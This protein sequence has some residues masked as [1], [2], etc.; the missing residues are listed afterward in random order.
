[1]KKKI[2]KEATKTDCNNKESRLF[3]ADHELG[4]SV[5]TTANLHHLLLRSRED[6]YDGVLIDPTGLPVD[7]HDFV[8]RLR[9]SLLH[10]RN[11]VLNLAY[12]SVF[13]AKPYKYMY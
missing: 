12:C 5:D 1:M 8:V 13:Q 6:C 2:M 11:Q 4:D 9:A 7:P 3:V 10:W